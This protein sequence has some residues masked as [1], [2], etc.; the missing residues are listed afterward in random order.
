MR[1]R[2]VRLL[3]LGLVGSFVGGC[4]GRV[5]GVGPPASHRRVANWE[6]M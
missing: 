6:S 2:W 1:S 4:A 5:V 3:V